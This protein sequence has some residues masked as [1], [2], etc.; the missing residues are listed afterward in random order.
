MNESWQERRKNTFAISESQEAVGRS[1][2]ERGK[3][4]TEIS[5]NEE[6]NT[7]V[8]T[9]YTLAFLQREKNGR[10]GIKLRI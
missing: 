1:E 4:R 6:G 2:G 8:K 9:S 7:P 3:L 10:M 5:N